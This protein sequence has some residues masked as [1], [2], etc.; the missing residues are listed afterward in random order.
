V[1]LAV[2]VPVVR[3]LVW[4]LALVALT[5]TGARWADVA[6]PPLVLV[7]S[8]SPLAGP[9]ALLALL[10]VAVSGR[11]APRIALAGT[12][13]AVLAVQAALWVPWL[14]D[15]PTRPG[16]DLTVMTVNLYKGRADFAAISRTVRA[17]HVDV[18]A[19]SEV[20]HAAAADLRRSRL[21]DLLTH[22]VSSEHAPATTMLLS[23]VPLVRP[24][25]AAPEVTGADVRGQ[26]ALLSDA[27]VIVC[28]VHPAPPVPGQ[29]HSWRAA[30]D[31]MTSW[32]ARVRGPIVIAGD[33]NASVDHPGMRELL[34]TGLRDAHELAG[35]GRPLTWP[36]GRT[37][38]PFVQIDHV[39]VRGLGVA[40][41]K[42]VRIPGSDHAAVVANLVVPA[43]R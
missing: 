16:Q 34:G 26:I 18:L 24:A 41:A 30:Q 27:G 14:T 35:A 8:L 20:T 32:A 11:R 21:D 31:E 1:W 7:Q 38:P 42:T 25:D 29:I 40:S 19:V 22:A 15:Q 28:A 43:G 3:A 9:V 13:V 4:A 37:P 36:Y 5:L 2:L 10:G 33:F 6:W 17:E 12:S 39:L 23:R